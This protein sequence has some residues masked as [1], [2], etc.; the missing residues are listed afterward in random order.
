MK[1]FI[2]NPDNY[3]KNMLFLNQGL[4]SSQSTRYGNLVVTKLVG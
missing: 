3:I 4:V 1:G 2:F